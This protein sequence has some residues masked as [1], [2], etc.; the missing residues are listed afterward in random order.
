MAEGIGFAVLVVLQVALLVMFYGFNIIMPWWVVWLPLLFIGF[1]VVLAVMFMV[2][3]VLIA[4][5]FN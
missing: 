4:I 2:A 3:V 5:V 1:L